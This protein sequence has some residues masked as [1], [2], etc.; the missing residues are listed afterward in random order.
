VGEKKTEKPQA[1]KAVYV[2][3]ALR[4]IDSRPKVKEG[5]PY[6]LKSQEQSKQKR[7]W[8]SSQVKASRA[9]FSLSITQKNTARRKDSIDRSEKGRKEKIQKPYMAR[10]CV[11]SVC[12]VK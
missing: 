10:R 9:R 8:N 12:G 4:L 2:G 7:S 11:K 6:D 5:K 1:S 3:L